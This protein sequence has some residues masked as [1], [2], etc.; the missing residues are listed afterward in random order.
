MNADP[1]D[2][3]KQETYMKSF[4]KPRHIEYGER[5]ITLARRGLSLIHI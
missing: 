4:F 5:A 3:L 1:A 2:P